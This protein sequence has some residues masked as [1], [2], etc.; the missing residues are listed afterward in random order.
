MIYTKEFIPQIA[1][2]FSM[3][4]IPDDWSGID[5]V[6]PIIER[7]KC[8]GAVFIIKIDGERGDD[9][10]GPYSILVFGKPLGELCI[11]T[12]AHNLD[13]GLT[14]VIGTYANHVWGISQS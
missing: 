2:H 14:Y 1:S 10:N 4:I 13:D 11:S 12:D 8:D 7:I 3:N 5:A 9:D 6:L